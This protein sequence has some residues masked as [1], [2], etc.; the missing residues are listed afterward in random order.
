MITGTVNVKGAI[1]FRVLVTN[2]ELARKFDQLIRE[3]PQSI[4]QPARR[5]TTSGNRHVDKGRGK[6]KKVLQLLKESHPTFP[7]TVVQVTP[8]VKSTLDVSVNTI[9]RALKSGIEKGVLEID[10]KGS[11]RFLISSSLPPQDIGSRNQSGNIR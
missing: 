8:L 9:R 7:F 2:W 4:A 11:Y 5:V 10:R 6:S 1:E 3:N